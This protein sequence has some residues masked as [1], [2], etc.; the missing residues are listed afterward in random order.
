MPILHSGNGRNFNVAAM[1]ELR[2][3]VSLSNR[4]QGGCPIHALRAATHQFGQG[5]NL[6]SALAPTARYLWDGTGRGEEV[7]VLE[8]LVR[9]FGGHDALILH[10]FPD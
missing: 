2:I 9:F 5:S 10:V 3:S 8:Q 7:E 6:L 4:T 1:C